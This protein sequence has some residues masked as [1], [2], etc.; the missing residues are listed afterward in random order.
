MEVTNW[1]LLFAT[2]VQAVTVIVKDCNSTNGQCDVCNDT[3]VDVSSLPGDDCD[4][5]ILHLP[6]S[7]PWFEDYCV[8]YTPNGLN[9]KMISC[10]SCDDY[11][12]SVIYYS[13]STYTG[14]CDG[15][16]GMCLK[17]YIDRSS[18][19]GNTCEDHV[20]SLQ[21][22]YP[23]FEDYC[24]CYTPNGYW[25]QMLTC[26]PCDEIIFYGSA[27]ND[28]DG[29]DNDGAD[30]DNDGDDNDGNDGSAGNDNDGDDNDGNDGSADGDDNG[31]D[32]DDNEDHSKVMA[33]KTCRSTNGQ[34]EGAC[35]ETEID[36]SSFSGYSCEDSVSY[37]K[38]TFTWFEDYCTCAMVHGAYDM[39][40]SCG[41]C[42]DNDGGAASSSDN[43][44]LIVGIVIGCFVLVV[45]IVT[46]V[47]CMRKG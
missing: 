22:T 14:E 32:D 3:E 11:P 8:C 45:G 42:D 38:R 27:G 43:T 41:T 33:L 39:M 17:T 12:P 5:Y 29:D 47:Y 28:N 31:G 13:C 7:Y 15:V 44:G 20:S 37:L 25:D 10:G 9:D 26:G 24:T 36:M 1:V 21:T 40:I 46:A 6:Y 2:F 23:W 16:K 18:L 35:T 34:C 19:P 4:D 30:D